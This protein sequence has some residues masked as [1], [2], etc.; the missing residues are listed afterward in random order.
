M[1]GAWDEEGGWPDRLKRDLHRM[2][3]ESG[4][5]KKAQ[6]FNLGIGGATSQYLLDRN[7]VLNTVALEQNVS[8]VKIFEAATA[9]AEYMSSFV[10]G[11]HP[12]AVGRQWLCGHIKPHIIEL[13]EKK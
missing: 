11:I 9:N 3:V 8:I 10:D 4:Q 7:E 2:T 13:L 5:E 1:Y 12:N 6:L